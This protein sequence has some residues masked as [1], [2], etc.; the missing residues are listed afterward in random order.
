MYRIFVS[1]CFIVIF[2]SCNPEGKQIENQDAEVVV[3]QKDPLPSWNEG[4]TKNAIL[5]YVGE[6]TNSEN[7]NFIEV[8][9]RIATFD[10]DGNLWAEQPAYFQLYFAIDR[11]KEMAADHPEWQT[12]QPYQSILEDDMKALMAQGEKALIQIIMTQSYG[13]FCYL[14]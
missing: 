11:I 2:V 4:E 7:S 1:I 8:K 12:E 9:D 3:V 5:N 10:N 6:V 14:G 13:H